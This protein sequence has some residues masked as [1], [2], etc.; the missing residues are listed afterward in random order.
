MKPQ[1]IQKTINDCF[2]L[3]ADVVTRRLEQERGFSVI[4]TR[5]PP[6]WLDMKEWE[7]GIVLSYDGG[8]VRIVLIAALQP[9][10]GAFGRLVTGICRAGLKPVVIEALPQ[11]TAI[12]RRWGWRK[13]AKWDREN[14]KETQWMPN[15]QWM[16]ERSERD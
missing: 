16:I 7:P 14:G 15:Q 1:D 2:E 9:C 4:D 12:L 5:L 6:P 10:T 11:M 3:G 13:V 8:R